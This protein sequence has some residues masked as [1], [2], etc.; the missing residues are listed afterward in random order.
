[1]LW[2]LVLQLMSSA[3]FTLESHDAR[4]WGYY[5]ALVM[6]AANFGTLLGSFAGWTLRSLL[7]EQQLYSWGWRLPFLSGI[8]VSVSGFY[9]RGHG[10]EIDVH[11][12]HHTQHSTT[13]TIAREDEIVTT[14]PANPIIMAFAKHN[15]RSLLASTL[16][17]MLSSGGFYLS[18]VWM[19]IFDTDLIQNPVKGAFGVNAAALFLSFCLLFPFVG[20]ISD[21]YGRQRIMTIGGVMMGLIS[22]FMVILIGQGNAALAFV[23]QLVIGVSLSFWNAPLLA[24]LAESF[25]PEARLTSVAIGYNM[26]QATVG[27]LTPALATIM[28]DALG[29]SSPGILLTFL[30]V[31]GLLGLWVAPPLPH[32][33]S[34]S[35]LNDDDDN[36]NPGLPAGTKKAEQPSTR[37]QKRKVF[38]AIPREDEDGDNRDIPDG[39]MDDEGVIDDSDDDFELI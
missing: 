21:Q 1:M 8:L 16:V 23:A 33:Q 15:R 14:T 25:E 24:W 27:G 38:S 37:R 39:D 12:P 5:S 17:P 30:A 10:D 29:P 18:F 35:S 6:G 2:Y 31:V 26:A 22:P 13:K 32:N 7:T 19:P 4:H 20:I 36:D 11:H 3:V 34:A 9:L 28:V